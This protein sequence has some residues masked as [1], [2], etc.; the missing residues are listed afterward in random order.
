MDPDIYGIE[1]YEFV[2]FGADPDNNPDLM[3]E[4]AESAFVW[5][6]WSRV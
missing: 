2:Q 6:W 5:P 4:N 1:I 3:E